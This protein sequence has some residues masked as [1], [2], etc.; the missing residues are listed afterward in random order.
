MTE[1]TLED[2]WTVAFL[3]VGE[4]VPIVLVFGSAAALRS[5]ATIA[6]D[7]AGGRRVVLVDVADLASDPGDTT[8]ATERFLALLASL[9]IRE[10]TLVG[11]TVGCA[12]A[13]RAAAIAPG[14]VISRLA[15]ISSPIALPAAP[16]APVAADYATDLRRVS[17]PTL[18]LHSEIDPMS[19]LNDT[20]LG[21]VM[22]SPHAQL[23]VYPGAR[24][25]LSAEQR[26][27]VI[28]D[29]LDFADTAAPL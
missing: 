25:A 24:E 28:R 15:L 5:A 2:G 11:H 10:A 7:A 9:E 13:V 27:S 23:R 21:A 4:G 19:P 18:V 17:I 14:G 12:V 22:A 26:E 1:T 16:D 6:G 20:A 29:L 8:V 3:A